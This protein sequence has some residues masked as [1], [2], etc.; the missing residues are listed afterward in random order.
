[1]ITFTG[2]ANGTYSF[3]AGPIPGYRATPGSGT[4]SVNGSGVSEVIE[5]SVAPPQ[6]LNASGPA[7][8]LGLPPVEGYAVLAGLAIIVVAGCVVLVVRRRGGT[9]APASEEP[10]LAQVSDE[11]TGD[12]AQEEPPS[13]S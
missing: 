1:D 9:V 3:D 10:R 4:L 11:P 6:G 13:Q 8:I 5:F 12:P 7:T 2:V